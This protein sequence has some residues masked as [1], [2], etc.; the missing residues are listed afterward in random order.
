M[1]WFVVYTQPLKETV[2][3]Q[4]LEEQ[5]YDVYLPMF[6]KTRRHAR[7]TDEVLQPLFPRYLFVGLDLKLDAWRAVNG[8]R[9]VA[10]LLLNDGHP[11]GISTSIIEELKVLENDGVVPIECVS[12]FTKGE[13]LRVVDGVFK[14]QVAVFQR[15]GDKQR[16]QLLLNFLGRDTRITVPVYAVEA[17]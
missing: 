14:D 1:R 4:H 9:G 6:K 5:G 10:Y 3:K 13:N 15:M 12:A 16:V 7:R 11:L 2:A 8:T 17:A